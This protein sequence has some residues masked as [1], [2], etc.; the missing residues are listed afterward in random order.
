MSLLNVGAVA[1]EFTAKATTGETISLADFRDKKNVVLYFYP[2]DDTPG[3]TVEACSFR[4][5]I[6]HFTNADTVVL[7]VSLDN[8]D[9]HRRFTEKFNLNFPL[10][11][12]TDKAICTAYG[13]EIRG[14]WPER[15]TYLIGKDGMVKNVFPKVNV[16]SHSAELQAAIRHLN[17][18][19]IS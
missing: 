8:V 7:G 9:S 6:A 18:E 5:D 10:L 12:D 15:V 1:P 3:C 13:V 4:D 2:E 19:A 14:N 16:R 17:D 11:A